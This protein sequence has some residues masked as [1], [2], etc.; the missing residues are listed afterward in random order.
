M[1]AEEQLS[2]VDEGRFQ[3][4]LRQNLSSDLVL[5]VL[6]ECLVEENS[7]Y[8]ALNF[9][10]AIKELQQHDSGRYY[11]LKA[12]LEGFATKEGLVL[13][14]PKLV[15]ES[16]K[17]RKKQLDLL[18]SMGRFKRFFYRLSQALVGLLN[19][20]SETEA[21]QEAIQITG[22]VKIARDELAALEAKK[23]QTVQ[24]TNKTLTE[25]SAKAYAIMHN[26]QERAVI[27]SSQLIENA[28]ASIERERGKM[29]E[30]FSLAYDKH[31]GS[32]FN[33]ATAMR[34]Q[35]EQEFERQAADELLVAKEGG[36][37]S[38]HRD[39]FERFMAKENNSW[40][41]KEFED[42]KHKA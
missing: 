29:Y 14:D 40:V 33:E 18:K 6:E 8:A 25:A 34:L 22:E 28:R 38:E 26:A 20:K 30:V 11:L 21:I 10:Q 31:V 7:T 15:N 37:R 1:I 41:Q 5:Q 35:L 19:E 16:Y 3:D 23:S 2:L 12:L 17:E 36:K 27:T 4:Y 13:L 24:E 9:S 39:K 32:R 42:G